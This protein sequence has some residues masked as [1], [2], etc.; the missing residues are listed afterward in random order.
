MENPPK[1]N[2]EELAY[3]FF[4]LNGCA[5]ISNFVVHPDQGGSQR[6]EVDVVAVRFPF[7][8][9]LITSIEP[10]LD[11][12]V[13]VPDGK[14]DIIIAEVKHG[15]CCLNGPWTNTSGENMHSVL[16]A[17]GAFEPAY[18]PDV[19]KALYQAG[20]FTNDAIRVRLFAIG[21]ILNPTLNPA[22]RQ[23]LWD[24]I[25]T[26]IFERINRYSAQKAHHD[27]WDR[28]GR[29]LYTFACNHT[30]NEFIAEIKNRMQNYMN[31]KN[32]PPRNLEREK[33]DQDC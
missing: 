3:W 20:Q 12:P 8:H 18:V 16:Y 29:M 21:G 2:P 19:A 25:L 6:T 32:A 15:L 11:H 23:L 33:Y 4:R 26:F 1:L 9:E 17:V 24:D 5:T 13:F 27:Q 30:I 7:R 10:M 22:V 28:T 14:I 31:K